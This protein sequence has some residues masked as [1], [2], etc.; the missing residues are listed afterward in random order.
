MSLEPIDLKRCQAEIISYRPFVMGGPVRTRE[1]CEAKPTWIAR[2]KLPGADGQHG[3]MSLC[4]ACK[5]QAKKKLGD[6]IRCT[7]IRR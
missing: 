6:T 4:D 3:A 1:R 2:E 5:M 7:G